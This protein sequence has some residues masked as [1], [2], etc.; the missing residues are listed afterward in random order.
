M[1]LT[2][3]ERDKLANYASELKRLA[4][5]W[6][7]GLKWVES[8]KKG[9][10]AFQYGKGTIVYSPV[11]GNPLPYAHNQLELVEW[12]IEA[13]QKKADDAKVQYEKLQTESK[14]FLDELVARYGDQLNAA[15]KTYTM[16]ADKSIEEATTDTSNSS[17][18]ESSEKKPNYTML[19]MIG[20]GILLLIL[21]LRK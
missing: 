13:W 21:L 18:Q 6:S 15:I 1:F 20:G 17:T 19:A 10:G 3:L 12:N 16:N 7:I 4:D 5:L 2:S 14:A 9:L 8:Y 11:N